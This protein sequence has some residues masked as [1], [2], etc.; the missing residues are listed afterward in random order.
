ML[1]STKILAIILTAIMMMSSAGNFPVEETHHEI[2]YEN[3]VRADLPYLLDQIPYTSTKFYRA[4]YALSILV[5]LPG[6]IDDLIDLA[7]NGVTQDDRTDA[8]FAMQYAASDPRIAATLIGL[9]DDPDSIIQY[10]AILTLA[11]AEPTPELETA[12][13]KVLTDDTPLITVDAAEILTK[14][15]PN[16]EILDA[17]LAGLFSESY[18]TQQGCSFGLAN[19]DFD[20]DV[21]V[22][23][24]IDALGNDDRFIRYR[25]AEV[26]LT[27]GPYA[28]EA[29]PALEEALNIED[30]ARAQD[31]YYNIRGTYLNAL[32]ATNPNTDEVV[33]IVTDYINHEF[34]HVRKAAIKGLGT[35]GPAGIE[36]LPDLQALVDGDENEIIILS[37]HVAIAQIKAEY[38]E[39][40]SDLTY[41]LANNDKEI[42]KEAVRALGTLGSRSVTA[43]PELYNLT[44]DPETRWLA[45]E[46][47][48][49]IEGQEALVQLYIDLLEH[50]DRD[51]RMGVIIRLGIIGPMAVDAIPALSE[52]MEDEDVNE[53]IRDNAWIAIKQIEGFQYW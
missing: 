51:F 25:A 40:L 11:Y 6:V 28:A 39:L 7:E 33:R 32:I 35:L 52:I 4:I 9:L 14:F 37:A 2:D 20:P 48:G 46:V 24:L 45:C 16:P 19:M 41:L 38:T 27:L 3:P 5:E 26:L 10:S 18:H 23:T 1:G 53:E 29:A 22:P 42:R 43:L 13:L 12:L 50:C 17:F 34:R 15:E 47:I 49:E 36:A 8:I 31:R 30:A 21:V 44:N